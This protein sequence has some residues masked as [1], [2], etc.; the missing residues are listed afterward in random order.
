MDLRNYRR[1]LLSFADAELERQDG[2]ERL[3]LSHPD[4]DV[5][6]MGFRIDSIGLKPQSN[7]E[8][9]RADFKEV[10]LGT[11]EPSSPLYDL[12]RAANYQKCIRVGGKHNDLDDVGKD[13]SHH[14]FFEMLGNWSFGDY[15]KVKDIVNAEE[16]KYLHRM[17]KAEAALNE[18]KTANVVPGHA[19]W[20]LYVQHGLQKDQITDL[21]VKRGLLVD[22]EQFEQHF[23]EFQVYPKTVSVIRIGNENDTFSQELCCGTHVSSLSDLGDIVVTSHHSVGTMVRSIHAVAGPLAAAVHSQDEYV[24][25][26]ICELAEEAEALNH[27]SLDDYVTMAA[28]RRKL[29]EVRKLVAARGISLLLQRKAEAELVKLERHI[30]SIIRKY[31]QN[32]GVPKVPEMSQLLQLC[33]S[34]YSRAC[35]SET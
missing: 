5:I 32:F 21:A 35:A 24:Q 2:H 31:N 18:V 13:L 20:E 4:T 14:T 7:Q 11:V 33:S 16:D 23:K 30:D 27:A 19:A 3:S 34:Q 6:L 9:R 29:T 15:F 17:S 8:S 10:F 26:Q 12:R 25:R 1:T 28:C 22:W